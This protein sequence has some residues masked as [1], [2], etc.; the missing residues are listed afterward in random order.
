MGTSFYVSNDPTNSVKALKEPIT[1]TYELEPYP[2][3]L[4]PQTKKNFPCQGFRKFIVLQ[5]YRQILPKHY[6]VAS[7]TVS[8]S[9]AGHGAV[10]LTRQHSGIS[11][12]Y[13]DVCI[14]AV[15]YVTL[16]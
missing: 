3:K 14:H 2:L 5:T 1:L 9:Q 8:W 7:R 4:Y 12:L 13:D 11:I 15:N 10:A 6:H 16:T